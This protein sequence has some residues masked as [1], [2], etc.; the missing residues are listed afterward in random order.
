[1]AQIQTRL[2]VR[3]LA[4][5]LAILIGL[6]VV[7]LVMEVA[8]R[9]AGIPR[10]S[11]ACR[12]FGESSGPTIF[13][14]DKELGWAYVPNAAFRM[15]FGPPR[16]VNVFFDEN[17]IRV[18]SEGFHLDPAKPSILFVGCSYTMG[19]ALFYEETVAGLIAALPQFQFQVVNLGVQAYG[20][21]QTLIALKKYISRFNTKL[22]VY[23]FMSAHV[24]RNVSAVSK[25]F[26]ELVG[27]QLVLQKV[28]EPI[29]PSWVSSRVIGAIRIMLD[30]KFGWFLRS[31]ALT[32]RLVMEMKKVT[33]AHG[34]KFMVIQ[35]LWNNKEN[36]KDIFK[37]L[38]LDVINTLDGAPPGWGTMFNLY[39]AHP[40]P[41]ANA[42]VAQLLLKR[43]AEEAS[44]AKP[45]VSGVSGTV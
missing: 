22:V 10:T 45:R 3:L 38:D 1:M 24:E 26:F 8:F 23:T 30:S 4:V 29:H 7:F 31:K 13:R 2:V 35:W 41:Q 34:A 36:T 28:F 6:C 32:R 44:G 11:V 25:P 33:E 43:L 14:A 9:I 39:D 42:H 40:L 16:W 17:G 18:P 27:D 21:D 15:Q 37:G 20:T 19:H 5:P 12:Q